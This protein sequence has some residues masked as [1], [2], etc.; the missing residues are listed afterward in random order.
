MTGAD[1]LGAR[2]IRG[3][4]SRRPALLCTTAPSSD[5]GGSAEA[6]FPGREELLLKGLLPELALP[7]HN[8]V[9]KF[10]PLITF[11]RS[12]A[13]QEERDDRSDK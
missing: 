9:R 11:H 3:G 12:A 13:R 8:G 1:R 4:A 7:L 6:P 2:L 5:S 10:L